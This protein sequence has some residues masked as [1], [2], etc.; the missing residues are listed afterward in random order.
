MTLNNADT[1]LLIEAYYKI[2]AQIEAA[3]ETF[4][5]AAPNDPQRQIMLQS[6]L[7]TAICSHFIQTLPSLTTSDVLYIVRFAWDIVEQSRKEAE[8]EPPKDLN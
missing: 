8:P 1:S 2:V 4:V 7:W 3:S 6:K 5:D